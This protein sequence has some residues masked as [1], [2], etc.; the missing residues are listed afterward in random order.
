[1]NLFPHVPVGPVT[2]DPVRQRILLRTTEHIFLVHFPAS[3]RSLGT[4]NDLAG[5]TI[6][7]TQDTFPPIVQKYGRTKGTGSATTSY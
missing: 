5:S 3:L 4:V 7:D 6:I 1:M 2:G